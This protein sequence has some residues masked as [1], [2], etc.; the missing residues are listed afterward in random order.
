MNFGAAP[1]IGD[2]RGVGVAVLAGK[3][4]LAVELAVVG[5]GM[6]VRQGLPVSLI[7]GGPLG[8][9]LGV[10]ALTQEPA[11][12]LHRFLGNGAGHQSD[13][14]SIRHRYLW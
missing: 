10:K 1:T 9:V 14:S 3:A 4:P 5:V 12:I 11:P 6:A 8:H 13:V 2:G 7:P